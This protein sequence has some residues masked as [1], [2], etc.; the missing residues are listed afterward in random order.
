VFG[1]V[2]L[3]LWFT[4]TT[5]WGRAH[6]PFCA[7][8]CARSVPPLRA[9]PKHPPSARALCRGGVYDAPL[10]SLCFGVR[11]GGPRTRVTRNAF[12]SG[13]AWTCL[14]TA[15]ARYAAYTNAPGGV[16]TPAGSHHCSRVALLV[17]LRPYDGVQPPVCS[18]HR[19]AL[20]FSGATRVRQAQTRPPTGQHRS[21]VPYAVF[22]CLAHLLIMRRPRFSTV[23]ALGWCH[24]VC[25]P[26]LGFISTA[27]S[28]TVQ[29]IYTLRTIYSLPHTTIVQPGPYTL[30]DCADRIEY[31]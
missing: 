10:L 7:I 27:C 6:E 8:F 2:K 30:H 15:S 4:R 3:Q 1:L 28:C 9:V 23:V 24:T 19:S 20:V 31:P 26:R 12:R 13:C 16:Y 21:C 22:R 18:F 25:H 17:A 5:L 11:F 14:P 29:H